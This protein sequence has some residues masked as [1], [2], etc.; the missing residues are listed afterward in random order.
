[1]TLEDS[2]ALAAV[3][4]N[5][6]IMDSEYSYYLFAAELFRHEYVCYE[7]KFSKLALQVSPA[8]AD[9]A[10]LWK[11]IVKGLVDLGLYEEAYANL[12]QIPSEKLF[13]ITLK[14]DTRILIYV[15]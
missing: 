10:P 12:M 1:M 11:T 4:P 14:H 3:L 9:K 5:S 15:F 7:V 2:T 8:G 13:V 6:Q